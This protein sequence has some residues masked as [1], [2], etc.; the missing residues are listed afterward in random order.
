MV[1]PDRAGDGILKQARPVSSLHCLP[2]PLQLR[3]CGGDD[4]AMCRH[5]MFCAHC[6]NIPGTFLRGNAVAAGLGI[7]NRIGQF[8]GFVAPYIIGSW[9]SY[10]SGMMII[11]AGLA[12]K[13]GAV[14]ARDAAVPAGAKKRTRHGQKHAARSQLAATREPSDQA[15]SN[16]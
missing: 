16:C 13:L 7:F 5:E 10:A 15:R 1:A 6:P 8:G 9:G 12:L 11:A 14:V 3:R 4:R 2:A